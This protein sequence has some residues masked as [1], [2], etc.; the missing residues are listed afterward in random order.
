[1]KTELFQSC[2]HCWVYIECSTFTASSFRIWNSSNGISSPPLALFAV[3]LPKA[4]LTLHSRISVSS[5]AGQ[6]NL[7]TEL[8]QDWRNRFLK[9]ANKT[10]CAPGAR[11]KEQCPHKRL[12]QTCP[13]VSKSLWWRHGWTVACCGVRGT[14]YN[15]T[16]ISPFEGGPHYPHYPYHSWASGQTTGRE[17]SPAHQQKIGLSDLL[18][19]AP[20]IKTRPRFPHSQSLPSGSFHKPLSLTH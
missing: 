11:R 1:M 3:R 14:E 10:L 17:H 13:W 7:I 5:F 20:P 12:S 15:S 4:H 19:M 2:G 18:S 6:W 16:G 8:S 9:G